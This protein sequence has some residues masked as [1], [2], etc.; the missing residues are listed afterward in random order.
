L[1]GQ[2]VSEGGEGGFLRKRQDLGDER[3]QRVVVTAAEGSKTFPRTALAPASP[4]QQRWRA[5]R[6]PF[7][8]SAASL[9][10]SRAPYEQRTWSRSQHFHVPPGQ[11]RH[12]S[13]RA[14]SQAYSTDL[15]SS[16]R[17]L[18]RTSSPSCQRETP[19]RRPLEPG[20]RYKS[21]SSVQHFHIPTAPTPRMVYSRPSNRTAMGRLV[22]RFGTPPPR[23]RSPSMNNEEAIE[24]SHYPGGRPYHQADKELKRRR[25]G[26]LDDEE[27]E[28]DEDDDDEE[29]DHQLDEGLDKEAGRLSRGVNLMEEE[30]MR[31][32]EEELKKISSGI[33]K[34]F[35]DTIRKTE[36]IRSS[37]GTTIDPRSA[38]RT[39]AANRMPKYR[40]RYDSPAWASPSRDTLH[41]RPWDSVEDL[42]CPVVLTSSGCA[43][44]CNSDHLPAAALASLGPDFHARSMSTLVRSHPSLASTLPRPAS[45]PRPGYTQNRATTLPH[46]RSVSGR[47]IDNELE[48]AGGEE[49][50]PT[51]NTHSGVVSTVTN[52]FSWATLAKYQSE[53]TN[54]KEGQSSFFRRPQL[55]HARTILDL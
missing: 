54:R 21:T 41:A 29:V 3:P 51:P 5:R 26:S 12:S 19:L 9:G 53:E 15:T 1:R 27:D 40:L 37:R 14:L 44:G 8:A 32:N 52:S 34:V 39:P 16:G 49:E 31:R 38:A 35:L 36:R 25:T 17:F 7:A 48:I 20:D 23:T 18:N 46:I 4:D 55:K 47:I 6:D 28:D 22:E 30:K 42:A 10:P 24:L 43:S 13:S 33:G 2:G 11:V 50:P 45:P